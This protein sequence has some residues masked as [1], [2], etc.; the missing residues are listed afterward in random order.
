VIV[1]FLGA[2]LQDEERYALRV[3]NAILSGQGG[4]LFRRLRDQLGL[5]YAVSS[6]CVEGLHHGY[7]AG[8]VA[9]APA[10]A[11]DAA[12]ELLT[13]FSRLA[14]GEIDDAEMERAQRKLVGGFEIAL[15]ENAFQ[16]AQM[17]LD[18]IYGL[19]YRAFASFADRV[20]SVRRSDVVAAAQRYLSPERHVRLSLGP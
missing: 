13:E 9:T 10:R 7:I 16:A 12:A 4:R 8:Y 20:F 14:A 11:E 3:G 15:Q 1:G 18:D 19:G 6:T 2:R 17:A 5:A